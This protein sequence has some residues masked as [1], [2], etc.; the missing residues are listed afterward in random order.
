MCF[1]ADILSADRGTIYDVR[2]FQ[3]IFNYCYPKVDIP[4]AQ[5]IEVYRLNKRAFKDLISND[6]KKVNLAAVRIPAKARKMLTNNFPTFYVLYSVQGA[7]LQEI[8]EG[9]SSVTYPISTTQTQKKTVPTSG[10]SQKA[11]VVK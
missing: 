6:G 2:F 1:I 5:E 3:I 8:A 7:M 10:I 11:P 9:N 4:K